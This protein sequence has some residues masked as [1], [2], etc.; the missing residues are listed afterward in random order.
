M[1]DNREV[2]EGWDKDLT[3]F[4]ADEKGMAGRKASA[5]IINEVDKTIPW[6]IGGAADLNESTL[7]RNEDPMA[8]DFSRGPMAGGTSTSASASTRWRRSSTGYGSPRSAPTARASSSSPTTPGPRSGSR[9]IMEIPTIHV[10]THDSIGVG[11]DGPTHQPIEQLANLRAVPGLNVIRPA[12]ANEVTEAWRYVMNL[13]HEPAAL[14]LTRQD[15]P[16]FDRTKY[17]AASGLQKGAYVM[18]DCRGRRARGS[19]DGLRQRGPA[20]R[21]RL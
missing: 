13:K 20:L 6:L 14:V 5:K 3:V 4:P 12:D 17:A 11:E 21:R 7:T 16:T 2:P 19:L 8:G 15:L 1:M 10:F 18:A 9:A